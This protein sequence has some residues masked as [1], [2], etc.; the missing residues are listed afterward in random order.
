MPFVVAGA[1]LRH[2]L[3]N[4]KLDFKSAL[5]GL[6]VGVLA[7][8]AIAATSPPG[9]AGRYQVT[10]TGSHAVILDTATGQAWS[11]FLSPAGGRTD[12]DFYQSK[13]VRQP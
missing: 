4:A 13:N 3:M 1:S 8:M 5:I 11:T 2:P 6:L 9:Q 7:T 12:G 10:G